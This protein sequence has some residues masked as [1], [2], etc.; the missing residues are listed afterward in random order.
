MI[1]FACVDWM[2]PICCMKVLPHPLECHKYELWWQG[3]IQ[4]ISVLTNN[5][6]PRSR[7]KLLSRWLECSDDNVLYKRFPNYWSLVCGIHRPLSHNEQVPYTCSFDVFC[8]VSLNPLHAK[9][10]Q[11][12]HK[13]IFTFMSF[14]Q[15]VMTQ[16]LK[17][18]P[19]ARVAPTYSI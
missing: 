18:L 6:M 10:V 14:L 1:Y 9:F 2:C 7:L 3:A 19:Q 4:C 8:A 16:V 13:H 5:I 12:E 17:I 11:R 15:I